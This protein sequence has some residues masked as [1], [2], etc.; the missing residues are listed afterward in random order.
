MCPC[1]G[2]QSKKRQLT[3]SRLPFLLSTINVFSHHFSNNYCNFVGF[4]YGWMYD[5]PEGCQVIMKSN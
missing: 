5:L 1:S 2:H 3:F 4:S